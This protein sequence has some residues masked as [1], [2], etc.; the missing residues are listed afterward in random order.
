MLMNSRF[1]Q[2]GF[3]LVELMIGLVVGM[4]VVAAALSLLTTTM[5][6]S[7]ASIK[8]TRLDQELRQTMTML[9]RDLRR[10]TI[11]DPAA[12]VLRVSLADPLTLSGNSGGVTVTS[13]GGHL[14]NIGQKAVGGTL[15]Y[16][17]KESGVVNVYRGTITG[18][19]SGAYSVTLSGTW[20][21]D[22]IKNGVPAGNW[23]I[24]RPESVVASSG[25]CLL[26]ASDTDFSGVYD[27]QRYGYRYNA[28]D[29]AVEI[30][31]STASTDTCTSG[32]WENLT[33]ERSV[34]IDRF[35]V[36]D[37]SPPAF[38]SVGFNIAIREYAITIRGYLKSD[39][40]VVRTI[41]ETVRVRNDRLS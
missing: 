16:T 6:S 13:S 9:T 25:S 29:M 18:F 40:S 36:D 4:I 8:M 33:D 21:V 26:F 5:S 23:N 34:V 22:V 28:T 38:A 27:N 2:T 30:R 32:T 37:K 19:N 10:A 12:D 31:T 20:P 35:I 1:R 7:N 11:W 14:A 17:V 15:I 24:L 39:P 3:G 41:Q